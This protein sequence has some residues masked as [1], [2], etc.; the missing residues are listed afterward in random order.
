MN[1]FFAYFWPIAAFALVLGAA[2][3]TLAFRSRPRIYIAAGIAGAIAAAALWHGPLGGA[4]RFAAS[5]EHTARFVLNDWEM[6]HVQGR[7][8]RDPLTRR[9]LLTGEADDF[10]RSELSKIMG[11]IPGVSTANWSAGSGGLAL[12]GEAALLASAGFLLGL[13]LAYL[14]ELRR[15]YNAQ[16]KW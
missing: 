10:Q 3:G 11:S 7:L 12:I 13:L 5:I 1:P 6:G 2:T 15:R 8:H 14:F 16:W 4:D 9:L